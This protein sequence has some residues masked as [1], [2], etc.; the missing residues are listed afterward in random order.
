MEDLINDTDL[1]GFLQNVRSK[2]R[3]AIPKMWQ[4]CVHECVYPFL[5]HRC[6]DLSSS[7]ERVYPLPG[8]LIEGMYHPFPF[9][10]GECCT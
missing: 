1:S 6:D 2:I 3:I 8:S 7:H 10:I 4:V 9:T 5:S